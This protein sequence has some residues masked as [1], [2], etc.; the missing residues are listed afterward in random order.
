MKQN[1]GRRCLISD[2]SFRTFLFAV[3]L[4]WGSASVTAQDSAPVAATSAPAKIELRISLP[5]SSVTAGKTAVIRVEIWNRSN[6]DIY[7]CKAL[8]SEPCFLRVNFDPPPKNPPPTMITD[9]EPALPYRGTFAEALASTWTK[10]APSSEYGENIKLGEL[11]YGTLDQPGSYRVTATFGSS[12]FMSRTGYEDMRGF[13]KEIA[14]LSG[15]AW[16]GIIDSNEVTLNVV[17][18]RK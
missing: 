3:A 16:S 5:A 9:F 11:S 7:V 8:G 10:V 6:R 2:M 17:S 12:G 15:A 13:A 4:L 1:S 14:Q 18:A